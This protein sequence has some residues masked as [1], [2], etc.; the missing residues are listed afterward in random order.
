MRGDI[1]YQIAMPL[2]RFQFAL[3]GYSAA[4]QQPHPLG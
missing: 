1:F 4:W 3:H 2:G